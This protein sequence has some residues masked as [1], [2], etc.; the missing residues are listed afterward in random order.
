LSSYNFPRLLVSC[1]NG[2]GLLFV[3]NDKALQI[4]PNDSTGLAVWGEDLV[5]VR[6]ADSG[7]NK[8]AHH[9]RGSRE[10][11][12]LS[13]GFLD[14]HDLKVHEDVLYAVQ[15]GNNTVSKYNKLFQQLETW[16][17]SGE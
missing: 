16:E 4:S 14:L 10:F 1:P 6:Q 15:T 11:I 13:T 5:T 9:L 8:I 7:A 17:F 12:Q 3:E 2:G